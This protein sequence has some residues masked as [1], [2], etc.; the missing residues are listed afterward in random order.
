MAQNL[1]DSQIP[2]YPTWAVIHVHMSQAARRSLSP[3]L[4]LGYGAQSRSQIQQGHPLMFQFIAPCYPEASRGKGRGGV[5][6]R[7]GPPPFVSGE[8]VHREA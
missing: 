8:V 6:P 5:P 1:L 2:S 7:T 3:G 4:F